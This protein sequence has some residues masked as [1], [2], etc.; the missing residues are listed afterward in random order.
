MKT[1]SVCILLLIGW[2]SSW[3]QPLPIDLPPNFIDEL[4]SPGWRSAVGFEFDANGR[5]YAWSKPGLVY[6]GEDG[7]QLE[8]PLLDIREEV[9]SYGDHGLLGFALHPNF[10][11]NGY[12]YLYYVVDRHHLLYYGTPDYSPAADIKD[13]ATIARI[14]RYTADPATGMTTVIPGSRK[15]LVGESISTG[16]PI[17]HRSHGGGALAFGNDGTLLASC[18]DG[19]SYAGTDV[20]DESAGAFGQQALADRII[21]PAENVGAFR[22]QLVNS[23]NGK[24]IRIDPNTGDGLSSNPFYDS[25]NPRSP[26]SRVWALGLRQPFRFV[27]MPGTGSHQPEDGDPGVF[28]LGDVG[29]AFWE[30]LNVVKEGGQNFGWPIYEGVKQ[31]WQYSTRKIANLTAPN[32]VSGQNG[33]DNAYFFFSDL[34][35]EA[36]LEPDP[37]FENPCDPSSDIPSDIPRFLHSRPMFTFSNTTWNSEEQNTYLPTFDSEGNGTFVSLLDS[38]STVEADTFSGSSCVAGV[39]YTGNTFPAEYQMSF[40]AMD[41]DGW[42]RKIDYSPD[43]EALA[44]EPFFGDGKFIVDAKVNPIDGCIYYLNYAFNSS[45]RRICYGT[46]PAPTAKM[47][48]D[49][50][51]GPSPLTVQFQGDQ[52]ADPEGEPLTYL[53]EFGDGESST[54]PNPTHIF[55]SSSSAPTSFEVSL[56]VEDSSGNVHRVDTLVSLNNT[57]PQVK[58][59]SF[60]DGDFYSTTGLTTLDLIADVSDAEHG[61]ESLTFAWQAHLHHNSHYHPEEIDTARESSILILGEGCGDESYWYRV[62]VTVTDPTGL[63]SYVEQEIFPFCG[64][65][66]T[67]FDT[68]EAIPREESILLQWQTLKETPGTTFFVQRSDDKKS[69]ET[70]HQL[71]ANGSAST[72]SFEDLTP[73]WDLNHYR[74]MTVGQDGFRE[75]SS[76]ASLDF[77]GVGAIRVFPNPV[78]DRLKLEF[79]EIHEEATIRLANLQGQTVFLRKW[80]GSGAN[81][82][83]SMDL[84]FLPPGLYMYEISDGNKTIIGKLIKYA[85]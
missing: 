54:E 26:A 80:L 37:F 8:Q 39:F 4:Y 20:G 15:I 70:L 30:E 75:Y 10:L 41:Y 78:A 51:Y 29:W 34:L 9:A 6:I 71:T 64:D 68:L 52:S 24:L 11:N 55:T 28:Y 17:L 25:A 49:Q 83:R 48:F 42:M 1:S 81:Q 56:Q 45:I 62:S 35:Q 22:S 7:Q 44:I 66:L 69:F 59:V 65:P 74:I 58:I 23:L 31:R 57:P 33:C 16:F 19:G 40:L 60:E 3:A 76:V 2:M 21:T 38:T 12:F 77:F 82:S 27:H 36:S 72:Y 43:H 73:E 47:K 61:E 46:N 67:I 63:A 79:S 84:S 13:E 5:L 18:G 50:N 14:T 32:P 53:W 85:L